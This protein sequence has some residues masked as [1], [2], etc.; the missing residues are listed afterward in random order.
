MSMA[1]TAGGI[2]DN[3]SL[4]FGLLLVIIGLIV[5]FGLYVANKMDNASDKISGKVD[6]ASKEISG[7]LEEL[8]K[9]IVRL[10]QDLLKHA[11]VLYRARQSE[12]G[13]PDPSRKQILL[14]K[15]EGGYITPD[16]GRELREILEAEARQA[17]LVGDIAGVVIILGV[18]ALIA[19]VLAASS[20]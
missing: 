7:R 17:Q 10:P 9:D 5:T 4:V 12:P 20:R 3:L 15:L 6:T 14:D 11:L 2:A 13:N 18:I 19:A 16:E 1:L 8:S